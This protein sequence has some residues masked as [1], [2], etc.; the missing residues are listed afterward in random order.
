MLRFIK[1]ETERKAT[2]KNVKAYIIS[3]YMEKFKST[4]DVAA[5]LNDVAEKLEFI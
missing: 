4:A 2:L 1:D 5:P 3:T